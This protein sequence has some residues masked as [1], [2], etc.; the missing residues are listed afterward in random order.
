MSR[1]ELDR[2]IDQLYE[3]ENDPRGQKAVIHQLV[4]LGDPQAIIEFATLYNKLDVD[5]GVKAA[6]A[7]GLRVF[8]RMEQ[9][10]KA[11]KK[12][13]RREAPVALLKRFR[14]LLV[15]LLA[16]TVIGNGL[17]LGMRFINSLPPPATPVQ[18]V[19]T[20]RDA[21]TARLKKS[22]SDGQAEA[23]YLRARWLELQGNAKLTCPGVFNGVTAINPAAIDLATYPDLKNV[24][25]ALNAG[26]QPIADSRNKWND[27]CNNA[28]TA[29]TSA[30]ASARVA[31]VGTA[32]GALGAAQ[33]ALDSWT[34]SPAPTVGPTA[35]PVTPT[36]TPSL[37]PT[38][39]RT[40]T[41]GPTN[42]ITPSP[43]ITPTPTVTPLQNISYSGL[44]LNNLTAY[45][46][47]FG[48]SYDGLSGTGGSFA[49]ALSVLVNRP[50][51]PLD[52][53]S[54]AQFDITL[55]E[56]QH[57]LA[58]FNALFKTGRV[59][60]VLVNGKYYVD[61]VV[62]A[63][64]G[65]KVSP[66]SSAITAPFE[67]LQPS[68][69]FKALLS[70][71]LIRV[72]TDET[73]NS[74]VAQHY[75]AQTSTGSGGNVVTI[76]Y[77][78]YVTGDKHLPVRV[79]ISAAGPYTGALTLQKGDSLNHYTAQYDLTASNPTIAIKAPPGCPAG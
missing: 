44:Q 45:S 18:T 27:V 46:Y 78:L 16:L 74:V 17:L 50:A 36:L 49:G 76:Y 8:W 9:R 47:K 2:L 67:T 79:K 21:L 23:I 48:V 41:P 66:I 40:P 56:D 14:V 12:G 75:H 43:T 7:D 11:K 64:T 65:C 1:T 30:Q 39:T 71:N 58:P 62:P 54:S 34:N 55:T 20:G 5:P 60:Y 13:T 19:A 35:T 42:T 24:T 25:D 77:D 32:N 69:F 57:L 68:D 10:I 61:T 59:N 70:A 28:S 37:T 4:Q 29:T 51:K 15:V 63:T 73:V 33:S 22:L 52:G 26:L 38:I 3:R 6:A 53:Q 31:D 72:P